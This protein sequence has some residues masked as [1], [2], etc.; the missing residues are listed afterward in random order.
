MLAITGYLAGHT[1]SGNS[2]ASA[3][4]TTTANA[5]AV[6]SP[7]NRVTYSAGTRTVTPAV[8]AATASSTSHGS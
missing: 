4:T 2:S 7:T 1:N 6:S 5:G 3:V 8:P